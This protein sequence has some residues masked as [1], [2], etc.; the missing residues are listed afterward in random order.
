[1]SVFAHLLC[2]ESQWLGSLPNDGT[3]DSMK[4][5][6]DLLASGVYILMCAMLVILI[7][8]YAMQDT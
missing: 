3:Y 5:V 7:N 8:L 1:V 6:G 2:N 4:H